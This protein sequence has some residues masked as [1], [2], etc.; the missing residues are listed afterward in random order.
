MPGLSDHSKLKNIMTHMRIKMLVLTMLLSAGIISAQEHKISVQN[1][2]EAKLIL[3]NFPNDLP[4]EGYSGNEI[5]ISADN[6]EFVPPERAKGLKPVYPGGNDN[7]GIGLSVEKN[8]STISVVCMLPITKHADYKIRVPD[9]LSLEIES[10]C[11]RTSNILVT[12]M[13]N[14]IEIQ[15]CY[16]IDLRNVTGPLV[17]STI[18]GDINISFSALAPD[19]PMSINAVSGEIDITLPAKTAANLELR[20]MGGSFWSDFDFSET[21]ENLKKVGGNEIG[22][23]LNGGGPKFSIAT[24]SGNVYIRKG[25]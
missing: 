8:G 22:Y 6:R 9:N 15:N 13:K 21:K 25:N 7:S 23:A 24:I 19:R 4:I 1:T 2:R 3:R 11:E 20:T 12:N 16:G 18:T 10:G 17:L 14:E 5:I